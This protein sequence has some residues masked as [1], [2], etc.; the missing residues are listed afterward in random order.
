MPTSAYSV[1]CSSGARASVEILDKELDDDETINSKLITNFHPIASLSPQ[2]PEVRT[3]SS[4]VANA[5]FTSLPSLLPLQSFFFSTLFLSHPPSPS[6]SF[7]VSSPLLLLLSLSCPIH[8]LPLSCPI[9]TLPL[10]L[11]PIHPST[12][13]SLE[14]RWWL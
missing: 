12:P 11:F 2:L 9:H 3:L 6:L 4:Y 10:S 7:A 14:S 8:T 5:H 1:V 13:T